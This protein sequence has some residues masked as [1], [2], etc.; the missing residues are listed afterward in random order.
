[1]DLNHYYG[2]DLAVSPAGDLSL[3]S[4]EL[5]GTQRVYRRL[6][7]NPELTD[8]SGNVIA[9]GDYIAHQDYGA[10]VGR[11]VGQPQAIPATKALIRGQ[12]LMEQQYVARS[13]APQITLTP[14]LEG[15]SAS[16]Q[17]TDAN[18]AAQQFVQFDITE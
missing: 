5:T 4:V 14:I 6:L 2:G 15:L 9:S 16:V 3:S 17:Y 10:G 12:M 11:L 1:M 7:T 13:P 18:T 8:S